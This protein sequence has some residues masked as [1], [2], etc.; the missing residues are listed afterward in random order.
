MKRPTL[1]VAAA[2]LLL[3]ACAHQPPLRGTGDLGFYKTDPERLKIV[4]VKMACWFQE[5]LLPRLS[6]MTAG[7]TCCWMVGRFCATM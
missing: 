5:V 7:S 1:L 2:S 4:S 3:A 6:W